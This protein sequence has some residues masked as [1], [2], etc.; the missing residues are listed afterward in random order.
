M[1]PRSSHLEVRMLITYI[2]QSLGVCDLLKFSKQKQ[3]TVFSPIWRVGMRCRVNTPQSNF[4]QNFDYKCSTTKKRE[5]CFFRN[6]FNLKG[7]MSRINQILQQ[8]TPTSL[9]ST[10][11]AYVLPLSRQMQKFLSYLLLFLLWFNRKVFW[12]L[13]RVSNIDSSF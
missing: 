5:S 2:T 1:V 11:P 8:P 9:L 13:L 3:K 6:V 12:V 10:S 4:E 7:F